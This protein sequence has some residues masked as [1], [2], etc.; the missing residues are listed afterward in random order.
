MLNTPYSNLIDRDRLKKACPNACNI[1][2][3]GL[4]AEQCILNIQAFELALSDLLQ[5]AS[6]KIQ[7]E[8]YIDM[9]FAV[10]SIR[11]YLAANN[12]ARSEYYANQRVKRNKQKHHKPITEYTSDELQAVRERIQ[13]QMDNLKGI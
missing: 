5:N 3:N 7:Q 1:P 12:K 13:F 9:L 8:V 2:E 11:L 10:R 4:K 6:G